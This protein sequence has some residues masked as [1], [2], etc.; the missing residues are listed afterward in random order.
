MCLIA[1]ILN[2]AIGFPVLYKESDIVL[3][4][5]SSHRDVC[6]FGEESDCYLTG[7]WRG[8]QF[9]APREKKSYTKEGQEY[10]DVFL[11]VYIWGLLGCN[12]LSRREKTISK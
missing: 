2:G 10:V 1:V 9:S 11:S 3:C 6:C 4:S 8:H 5:K 7:H 12:I